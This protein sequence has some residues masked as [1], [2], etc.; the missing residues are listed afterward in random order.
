MQAGKSCR[1]RGQL[2]EMGGE[3]RAATIDVVQ[4]LD[5]RP[6]DRQ[7]VEGGGAAPDLIQDDQRMRLPA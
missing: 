2:V 5:R 4:M 6:G 7:P 1:Q 3:Q